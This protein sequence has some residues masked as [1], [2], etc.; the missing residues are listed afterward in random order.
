M[1]IVT[2]EHKL[3]LLEAEWGS[4]V[5][6]LSWVVVNGTSVHTCY[7]I[8]RSCELLSW[9]Q[10]LRGTVSGWPYTSSAVEQLTSFLGAVL[11]PRSTHGKSLIQLEDDSRACKADFKCW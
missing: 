6:A 7:H 3:G 11:I 10:N 2:D 1:D 5:A 9:D 4:W 8:W